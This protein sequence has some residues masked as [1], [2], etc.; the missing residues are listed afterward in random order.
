MCIACRPHI[1]CMVGLHAIEHCVLVHL[2]VEDFG[3][4]V[5]HDIV[6]RILLL[7]AS[8]RLIVSLVLGSVIPGLPLLVIGGWLVGTV[9]LWKH[10]S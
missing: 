9:L 10:L 3:L 7:T 6:G 1:V 2:V 8:L 5:F 4:P